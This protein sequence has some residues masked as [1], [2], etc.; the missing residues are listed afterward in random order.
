MTLI[1]KPAVFLKTNETEL[2][3]NRF[4]FDYTGKIKK[5]STSEK[6]PTPPDF[7]GYYTYLRSKSKIISVARILTTIAENRNMVTSMFTMT[8]NDNVSKKKR[9]ELR[10]KFLNNL[11]HYTNYYLHVTEKHKSGKVHFHIVFLNSNYDFVNFMFKFRGKKIKEWSVKYCNSINGLDLITDANPFYVTKYISKEIKDIKAEKQLWGY[12]GIKN[13]TAI[14]KTLYLYF[15]PYQ[16]AENSSI[17]LEKSA[18]YLARYLA[19]PSRMNEMRYI[20]VFR[21]FH[22]PYELYEIERKKEIKKLLDEKEKNIYL[23]DK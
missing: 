9:F 17:Y 2:I 18:E 4:K 7:K 3:A 19:E 20:I 6:M 10:S 15:Q 11:K 12:R 5:L 22:T 16:F 14:S 13:P 23:C 21:V 8:F 1:L